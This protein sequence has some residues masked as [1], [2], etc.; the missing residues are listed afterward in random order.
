MLKTHG[1]QT[2]DQMRAFVAGAQ[3]IGFQAPARDA[4]YAWIADELRRLQ[5]HLP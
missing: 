3:P 5:Q 2:L 1:L 4:A